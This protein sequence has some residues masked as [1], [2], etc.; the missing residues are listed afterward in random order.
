M[1][2]DWAHPQREARYRWAAELAA[3]DT[4]LDAACGAGW[5]TAVLASRAEA[6]GVDI[7][8]GAIGEARDRHGAVARFLE[9]DIEDLPL[10]AGEFDLVACFEALP[11][12]VDPAR[13]LDELRRVLR[14]GGLLLA[15]VP[16][17]R[18][19]PAGTPLHRNEIDPERLG[20]LL[21]DRFARVALHRQQSH[22]ASLLGDGGALASERPDAE[23]GVRV[24]GG[25]AAAG[26]GVELH[27]VAV[28]GDGELPAPPVQVAIGGAATEREGEALAE[29]RRRAVEAEAEACALRRKL[30]ELQS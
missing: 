5:G 4:A 8:P 7:S 12:L 3:G 21:R 27:T 24:S 16:N 17:P 18:A 30:R 11:Q 20:A 22:T 25:G 28:A 2:G 10:G 15:S 6:T 14:P 13:A 23:P 9:G 1:G 19:Y 26:P 29:W